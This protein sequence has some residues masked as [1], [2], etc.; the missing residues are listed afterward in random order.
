M[1]FGK[2]PNGLRPFPLIFRK[3]YESASGVGEDFL[4]R[5]P[6][7]FYEN[8]RNSEQRF[9]KSIPKCEIDRLSE[10]YL[11]TG[12]LTKFVALLLKTDFRAEI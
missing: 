5:R 11:P 10:G 4:A 3:L 1:I 12:P 8:G 2:I 6:F 9:E 7:F